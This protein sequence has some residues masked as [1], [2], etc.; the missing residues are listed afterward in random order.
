MLS[1]TI[2]HEIAVPDVTPKIARA[3]E[4]LTSVTSAEQFSGLKIL[5]MHDQYA[6]GRSGIISASRPL[7]C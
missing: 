7:E 3:H 2:A 5:W 6:F 1:Q 4:H